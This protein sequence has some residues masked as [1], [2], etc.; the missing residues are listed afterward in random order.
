MV[1]E[2]GVDVWAENWPAVSLFQRLGTQFR[3]AGGPAGYLHL[4]LDYP[5]VD[6]VLRHAGVDTDPDE[7]FAAIQMMEA[8]ALPILN[9]S[10]TS[11]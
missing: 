10:L 6:V 3:V 4:G 5:A 11:R 8:V 9:E 2:T 7:L 1:E